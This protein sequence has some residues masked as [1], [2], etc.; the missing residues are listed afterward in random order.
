MKRSFRVATL[1]TGAAAA[2]ALSPAANAVAMPGSA[3]QVPRGPEVTP[4]IT[5]ENCNS[6][7]RQWI[8]LYYTAAED[9]GPS[10]LGHPGFYKVPN[11]NTVFESY[12]PGNN[13]GFISGLTAVGSYAVFPFGPSSS[14]FFV[15]LHDVGVTQSGSASDSYTCP[16]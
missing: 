15:Q 2:V 14:T 3:A 11:H 12:C 10:C 5:P 16:Q 6:G 7:T 8:H 1:F 13:S 9:H 4:N